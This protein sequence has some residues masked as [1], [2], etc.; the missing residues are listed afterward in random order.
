MRFLGKVGLFLFLVFSS[1][2]IFAY[3]LALHEKIVRPTFKNL[4]NRQFAWVG[5]VVA[6]LIIIDIFIIKRLITSWSKGNNC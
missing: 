3:S 5:L 2:I 6:G 1:L 4:N